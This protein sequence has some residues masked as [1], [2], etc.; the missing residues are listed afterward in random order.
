MNTAV[1]IR[2]HPS[3]NSHSRNSSPRRPLPT[4]TTSPSNTNNKTK[5]TRAKGNKKSKSLL[6]VSEI[7]HE[8]ADSKS[9]PRKHDTNAKAV[10]SYGAVKVMQRSKDSP[11]HHVLKEPSQQPNYRDAS[12]RRNNIPSAKSRRSQR[13]REIVAVTDALENA[14]ADLLS[15][16]LP[17]ESP[18][19]VTDSDDSTASDMSPK[20]N[21]KKYSIKPSTA[22]S[23]AVSKRF[24]Y[25]KLSWLQ[26][27]F[28]IVF[29]SFC[30][31]HDCSKTAI[32]RPSRTRRRSG[33]ILEISEKPSSPKTPPLSRTPPNHFVFGQPSANPLYAGPTFS[34]SPA[35]SALPIP[36]TGIRPASSLVRP[37]D[38]N[39]FMMDDDLD[40][41]A[42]VLRQKSRDLLDMLGADRP[43]SEPV[44]HHH[45]HIPKYSESFSSNGHML[46]R[47]NVPYHQPQPVYQQ[48]PFKMTTSHKLQQDVSPSLS[49]IQQNLRTMLKISSGM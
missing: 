11:Q 30:I 25:R 12:K 8:V 44:Q 7:K 48:L 42:S 21:N 46:A 35:P 2:H 20:K 5:V 22:Q 24:V 37:H 36:V 3:S 39:L 49:E 28:P 4:T 34:N 23:N 47:Y 17:S 41:N 27:I 14:E 32:T 33:S 9:Q 45:H 19:Q 18:L 16:S 6:N 38:D 10:L 29:D 31:L 40:T 13:R 1:A 26:L 43:R 15:T